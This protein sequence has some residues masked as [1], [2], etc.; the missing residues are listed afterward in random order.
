MVCE[1]IKK[2]IEIA[3]FVEQNV[4]Y[5]LIYEPKLQHWVS[6]WNSKNT[7]MYKKYFLSKLTFKAI[8]WFSHC[9]Q[10]EV[11]TEFLNSYSERA[12]NSDPYPPFR[13]HLE[14]FRGGGKWTNILSQNFR[15]TR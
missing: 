1:K 7:K 8:Q 13:I 3:R 2:L 4:F 10:T 15:P 11:D 14:Y 9:F 5:N 12:L 6:N